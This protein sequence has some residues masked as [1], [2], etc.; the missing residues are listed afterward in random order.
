[1]MIGKGTIASVALTLLL[2]ASLVQAKATMPNPPMNTSE[3]IRHQLAL[4]PYS[5]IWDWIEADLQA[6][7]TVVLRGEVIRPTL[8]TD[9]KS[10]LRGIESVKNVVDDIR[11]LPL[12]RFDNEVRVGVYRALFNSNSTLF[13]YALGVNP[14]IHIIVDNGHVTLKGV[15]SNNMDRQLAGMAANRVFG[16]FSVNN[17]L[18]VET[19][20]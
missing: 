10:R 16:V 8:K 7:G 12:S 17:E 19:K 18:E 11:V 3:Q 6:D 1:M 2:A 9:A 5:S 14:S 20:S 13:R 4:L 15:V